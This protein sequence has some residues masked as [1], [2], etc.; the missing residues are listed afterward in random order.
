MPNTYSYESENRYTEKEVQYFIN[1]DNPFPPI[2]VENN[3]N[4]SEFIILGIVDEN[5]YDLGWIKYK[6]NNEKRIYVK[7]PLSG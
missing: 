3:N 7:S 5:T 6:Y 1:Y 4:I 2:R